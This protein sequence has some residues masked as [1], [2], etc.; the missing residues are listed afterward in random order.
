LGQSRPSCPRE[1]NVVVLGVTSAGLF[2]AWH[3][4]FRLAAGGRLKPATCPT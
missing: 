1:P 3:P 2:S 4:T